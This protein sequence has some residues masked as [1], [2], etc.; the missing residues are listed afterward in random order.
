MQS[1]FLGFIPHEG[2]ADAT[3]K[4]GEVKIDASGKLWQALSAGKEKTHQT[5]RG[6]ADWGENSSEDYTSKRVV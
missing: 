5:R 6:W 1:A 2:D 3:G 4:F